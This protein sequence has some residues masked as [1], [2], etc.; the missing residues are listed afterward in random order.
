MFPCASTLIKPFL[1]HLCLKMDESF[2]RAPF[3]IMVTQFPDHRVSGIVVGYCQK[4]IVADLGFRE[5]FS[6][7]TEFV[8]RAF[9]QITGISRIQACDDHF[10]K[11]KGVGVSMTI[12]SSPSL[13]S[14]CSISSQAVIV[15]FWYDTI[16]LV[17][18][19][20]SVQVL[21]KN[22]RHQETMCCPWVDAAK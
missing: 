17:Q 8:T 18:S 2:P 6:I 16:G 5:F 7:E 11:C 10:S 21:R 14:F 9:S 4:P 12:A 20:C 19:A 15:T 3:G 13:F 22:N 1:W